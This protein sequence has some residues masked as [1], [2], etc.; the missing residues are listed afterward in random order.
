VYLELESERF[1][2]RKSSKTCE[3]WGFEAAAAVSTAAAAAIN[4]AAATRDGWMVKLKE[5]GNRLRQIRPR[6][7]TTLMLL[8]GRVGLFGTI[9][10]RKGIRKTE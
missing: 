5:E 3:N 9:K 4:A 7:Q 10:V 6:E 2:R 8:L 1:E